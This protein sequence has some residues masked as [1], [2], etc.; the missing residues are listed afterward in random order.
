MANSDPKRKKPLYDLARAKELGYKP[1]KDGHLPSRDF[2]TGRI[3]KSPAH[4][5]FNKTIENDKKLGYTPMIDP[6]GNVYTININDIPKKGYFSSKKNIENMS[7]NNVNPVNK[8]KCGGHPRKS[9]KTQRLNNGGDVKTTGFDKLAD[10]GII[11]SAA[12]L[13]VGISGAVFDAKKNALVEGYN[14]ATNPGDVI[15]GSNQLDTG[16]NLIAGALKG[17]SAGAALGPL[18]AGIGAA[19]GLTTAG[20]T[21]LINKKAAENTAQKATQKW[22]ARNVSAATSGGYKNGGKI[23]GPGTGKSDSINMT[24]KDGS[25]IVPAENAT[26]GMRLGRKYLGWND[27]SI[28][29]RKNGGSGIKVSDG[30]VFFTPEEVGALNYH[31][32]DLNALAPNAEPGN[33]A[34][35]DGGTKDSDKKEKSSKSKK[36]SRYYTE[37]PNDPRIKQY[38]DSLS[39]YNRN[40]MLDPKSSTKR[41][42]Q[43]PVVLSK[44]SDMI[45]KKGKG[46][47][48]VRT[49]VID[50]YGI[51]SDRSRISDER[52]GK[53]STTEHPGHHD[54]KD[55]NY[56]K[57]IDV[58][59]YSFTDESG[60]KKQVRLPKEEWEKRRSFADGGIKNTSNNKTVVPKPL[61]YRTNIE[62]VKDLESYIPKIIPRGMTKTIAPMPYGMTKS[63]E[64]I[65]KMTKT[66]KPIH[67]KNINSSNKENFKDG[68]GIG[69]PDDPEK[70]PFETETPITAADEI[71]TGIDDPGKLSRFQSKLSHYIDPG[72]RERESVSGQRAHASRVNVLHD[73]GLQESGLLPG[74]EEAPLEVEDFMTTTLA[75][76]KADG[77]RPAT[78]IDKLTSTNE[79][80]RLSDLAEMKNERDVSSDPGAP[81]ERGI[82]D[83]IPEIAGT[84]QTLGA[85]IGLINAG[86][87]PDLTISN[88]LNKLSSEVR[89]SAQFGYDAQTINAMNRQIDKAR[90]DF[91]VSVEARG[92]SASEIMSKKLAGLSTTI[93]KKAGVLFSDAQEKARKWADVL[94][95]DTMKAGQEF[96]INKINL[97]DYYKTQEMYAG[98]LTAGV[99]NIVGARQLKSEQ[100]RLKE[101]GTSSP[102][103]SR[104]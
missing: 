89:R 44:G 5:T 85:S 90:R 76:P 45:A 54:P 100:D 9:G 34:L 103:Y 93:D 38:A 72:K 96:D 71:T 59:E 101:I 18:G 39:A 19:A 37:D 47:S 53:R 83:Y 74:S 88:T 3:L 77:A 41:P 27:H 43:L 102:T 104:K 33:K 26:E 36:T 61:I 22:S 68:G 23:K 92:G 57:A 75:G 91:D 12:D 20:I 13:G 62:P 87:K 51:P 81:G 49:N 82:L 32:I 30:E 79:Q 40:I 21:S 63:I 70:L 97:A 15:R 17:A 73:I 28:A 31:G 67:H 52:F 14:P 35:A 64:P 8:L 95:V 48:D 58:F 42:V 46:R 11:G 99:S 94:K 10:S 65:R 55:V 86:K 25:F 66:I 7:R 80:K 56:N 24:A 60:K 16:K 69:N 6:F 78:A 29:A 84:I 50:K 4:P 2:E 98:M 1:D